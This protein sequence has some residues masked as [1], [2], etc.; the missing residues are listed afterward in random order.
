MGMHET[1][2][3]YST[4]S[5]SAV[6]VPGRHDCLLSGVLIYLFYSALIPAGALLAALLRL[7]NG[8]LQDRQRIGIN[9]NKIDRV[10]T[11]RQ[12]ALEVV[13]RVAFE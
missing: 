7:E 9:K 8:M 10:A 2:N 5:Q 6:R 12:E 11:I 3:I 4:V 13:R 1:A